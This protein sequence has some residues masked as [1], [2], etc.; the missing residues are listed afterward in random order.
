MI[1]EEL[2][3]THVVPPIPY[4][5]A[6]STNLIGALA[7]TAFTNGVRPCEYEISISPES[8]ASVISPPV[9]KLVHLTGTPKALSKVFLTLASW[10][11]VA[12]SKKNAI[13]TS[14]AAE[15]ADEII[16]LRA[17]ILPRIKLIIFLIYSPLFVYIK[18]NL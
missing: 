2:A 9:A 4:S 3:T 1:P 7:L 17:K 5:T 18:F 14:F 15:N 12:H 13:L 10:F 8:I 16:K 11:G 6:T